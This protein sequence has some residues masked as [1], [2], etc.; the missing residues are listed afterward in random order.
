[1]SILTEFEFAFQ[2]KESFIL[3]MVVIVVYLLTIHTSFSYRHIVFSI[4]AVI[5][6]YLY[7][8]RTVDTNYAA[9]NIQNEKLN[10]IDIA[11]YPFL[12]EDIEVIDTLIQLEP[13]FYVNRLQYMEVYKR[14][15]RFFQ[16]YKELMNSK[17]IVSR[18]TDLYQ[19]AKESSTM[20]F[21]ALLSFTIQVD[22]VIERRNI[23]RTID[24][25]KKR[26]QL[27]LNEMETKIQSDWNEGEINIHSQPIYPDEAS[28]SV[29]SDIQFSANYN[30]Y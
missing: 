24:E 12:Q 2:K 25:L 22:S 23:E 13:L 29:L 4:P 1:M 20:A 28:P 7:Y 10:K 30:I 5:V 21:N 19:M 6:G 16:I 27:F 14:L 3:L 15:N 9:M 8:T 18:P 11:S 17:H 26:C